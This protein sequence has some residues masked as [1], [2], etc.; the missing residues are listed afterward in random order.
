[1]PYNATQLPMN[2]EGGAAADEP[3]QVDP[4]NKKVADEGDDYHKRKI[5]WVKKSLKDPTAALSY[6][7]SVSILHLAMVVAIIFVQGADVKATTG[8]PKQCK[9]EAEFYD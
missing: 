9:E 7:Q 5:M 3:L 1:M 8:M 4:Q 6:S 2:N